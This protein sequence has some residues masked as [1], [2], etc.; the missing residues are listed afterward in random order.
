[1][2]RE[3][4]RVKFVFFVNFLVLFFGLTKKLF[5]DLEIPICFLLKFIN[6]NL[7]ILRNF[8]QNWF[9][10]FTQT[11]WSNSGLLATWSCGFL[12]KSLLLKHCKRLT[13]F[14]WKQPFAISQFQAITVKNLQTF[15]IIAHFCSLHQVFISL[16][17]SKA[18]HLTDKRALHTIHLA[19]G[20]P[21]F[22]AA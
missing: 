14:V 9:P 16:I 15:N 2:S 6:Y 13:N 18:R 12:T 3:N 11:F 10:N 20:F 19:L 21:L 8:F 7:T 4:K 1:M 5:G 22:V 17:T